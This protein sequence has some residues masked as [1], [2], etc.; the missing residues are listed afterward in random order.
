MLKLKL[1]YF[2]HLIRR[3]DSLEET[4]MLGKIEGRRRRGQQ[5]MRLLDGITDSMEM[6]FCKLQELGWIGSSWVLQST[7]SQRVG[8]DWVTEM[9]C[10]RPRNAGLW[11]PKGPYKKSAG[12]CLVFSLFSCL[13]SWGLCWVLWVASYLAENGAEQYRGA[14][15][16]L[17][18]TGVGSTVW[19]QIVR[20]QNAVYFDTAVYWVKSF[21]FPPSL[22]PAPPPRYMINEITSSFWSH[23]G[24]CDNHFLTASNVLFLLVCVLSKY[25]SLG[26]SPESQIFI[27]RV[28]LLISLILSEMSELAWGP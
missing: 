11:L 17:V 4:L 13:F 12:G 25:F 10:E 20:R 7:G 26:D 24:Q 14:C 18:K 22:P 23:S 19:R 27:L 5:R 9:N 6:S 21:F 16:S 15:W 2:G 3:T 1:Q 28:F 8:H